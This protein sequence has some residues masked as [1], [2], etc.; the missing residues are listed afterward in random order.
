MAQRIWALPFLTALVPSER[1]HQQ[2]GHRH[3]TLLDWARQMLRLV[4]RW[5]PGRELIVVA[6]SAY[7]SIAWLHDLRQGHPITGACTRL[8]LDAALYEPAPERQAG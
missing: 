3:K 5:C 6:D 8:R 1:Y 4:Q 2:R 7:A